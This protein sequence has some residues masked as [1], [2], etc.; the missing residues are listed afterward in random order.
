MKKRTVIANLRTHKKWVETQRGTRVNE[1]AGYEAQ[2]ILV[3]CA[4]LLLSGGGVSINEWV[5]RKTYRTDVVR[6]IQRTYVTKQGN[7][8]LLDLIDL[9]ISSLEACTWEDDFLPG[10]LPIVREAR[11][12]SE[13]QQKAMREGRDR[14]R[15]A[16]GR[17]KLQRDRQKLLTALNKFPDGETKRALR[18]ASVLP[19][20]R[21]DIALEELVRTA[22]AVRCEVFKGNHKTPHRGY[23]LAS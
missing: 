13:A 1:E 21:F 19:V 20:D 4:Q 7:R 17:D 8:A 11:R 2:N 10:A 23:R 9:T 3:G 15:Q 12:V 5:T 22:K 18:H 16:R 14:A 6:R